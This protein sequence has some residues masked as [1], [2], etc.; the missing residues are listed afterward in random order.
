MNKAILVGNLGADPE[1]VETSGGGLLKLRI[2]TT[3]RVKLDDG[4]W[5]NGSEWHSVVMFGKSVPGLRNILRKGHKVC[6]E[7]SLT[8]SSWEKDGQKHYK[9][10]VRCFD[11]ELLTPKGGGGQSSGGGNF[12]GDDIPF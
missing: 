8:T 12:G 11:L 6:V 5:G 7:G 2:A 3:E 1:F 9:T 4:S 10:E